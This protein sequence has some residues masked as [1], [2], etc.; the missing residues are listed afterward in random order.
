MPGKATPT[1]LGSIAIALAVA[2]VLNGCS[3]NAPMR[4][5][6][7]LSVLPAEASLP[8]RTLPVEPAITSVPISGSPSPNRIPGVSLVSTDP[9]STIPA[10]PRNT[11]AAPDLR[12]I[13][14]RTVQAD[15]RDRNP[16]IVIPGVLGTRLIHNLTGQVVWGEFGG[17]GINPSTPLGAQLMSLP[18]QIGKPLV[19]LTDSVKP[20]GTLDALEIHVLGIPFQINA[21]R[22][23]LTTLG[24]GGYR[25]D[26]TN[27][28]NINYGDQ[29][30]SSFQFAYDWRRDNVENARLLHQFILEKKAYVEAE[31]RER[32]GSDFQPV[33][34]DIVAHSMGGLV[35][36]YYLQYGD[37]DL[38][39]DGSVPDVTWNGAKH[40]DRLI[41]IATPNAGAL[42]TIANLVQGET[43]SRFLPRY[44]AAILGTMP[45]LYQ[46]LPRTRQRPVVTDGD[47]RSPDLMDPQVWAQFRWGLMDPRQNVV[48]SHLLPQTS[49]R[50]ARQK[51]AFDHLSKCLNRA[52]LF[53]QAM[54]V[55]AKP[56][57]GTS[58]HLIAG[59]AHPTTSQFRVD[60]RGTLTVTEWQPG[61]GRVSRASALMDERFS[62][63]V[64]WTP[65]LV[66]PIAW[67]NVNFL[68]ADH[69]G[70]TSDP[71]FSDNI[72]FLLLESPR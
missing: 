36:R 66:S 35:A 22:D 33:R 28:A 1:R 60:G 37:A 68:F 20:A 56:P 61:D 64:K 51:I 2:L 67:S 39:E 13:Y 59:D 15:D 34:F 57:A 29:N 69:L 12:H 55:P 17:D 50:G 7:G 16:I 4:S 58:I 62:M 9:T 41:M 47:R 21:Y 44:E 14:G 45:S 23:L 3:S 38:P 65:R 8:P 49:D 11:A 43:L 5:V 40:V 32:H 52:K 10:S 24:V 31:R 19:A 46:L 27:L 70:L 53:H 48:L 54:D 42:D 63:G 71:G 30:Y 26:Q 72:L 25:D 18:M 6:T